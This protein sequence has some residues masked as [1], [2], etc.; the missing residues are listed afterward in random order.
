MRELDHLQQMQ[1]KMGVLELKT[2]QLEIKKNETIKPECTEPKTKC[3]RVI[4]HPH[5]H[6]LYITWIAKHNIAKMNLK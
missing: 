2:K 1:V 5:I 4:C 3:M 6:Q